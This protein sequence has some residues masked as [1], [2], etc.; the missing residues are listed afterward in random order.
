M[1]GIAGVF[2]WQNKTFPRDQFE[3]ALTSLKK[4]GPDAS[5]IFEFE[6]GFLGHRRLSIIDTS[7][8]ANQPMFDESGRYCIVFNGEI[9]NFNILKETYFKNKIFKTQSDTELLLALYTLLKEKCLDLLDGFFSFVIYD[10]ETQSLFMARD[11]FGKKPFIYFSD[12]NGFYFASEMK[13][14]IDMG[15]NR[16]INYDALYLYFQLNYV[17]Q[18]YSIF[19][20]AYKLAPGHY[21]TLTRE[22][23]FT[24]I[25][26]YTT[27]VNVNKSLT[28]E[29]ACQHLDQL[30]DEA[31]QKRLISDVPLGA[32]L[33]GGIDSS[34]I[35]ALST[36]HVNELNTFSIGYKNNPVFDET[37]FANLVAK[38]FKTNHTVFSLGEEDFLEHVVDVLDSLDE[39]FADSSAIPTYILSKLTRKHV[40]VALS[41]DGG[42]EVFSGYNKHKAEWNARQNTLTNKILQ[43]AH[44]LTK[45]LPQGRNKKITNLFRQINRYAEGVAL[46]PK[47]RYWKWASFYSVN[48]V[49]ELL[50]EKTRHQINLNTV[51]NIKSTFIDNINKTD[52]NEVLISDLKLVLPSNMLVKVD[53]MSM[54]NSLEIRSP[55]LDHH[56]VDYAF[57]LPTEFKINKQL[58]KR[59]VQD[60]FRNILP[61]EL[62]NRPKQGFEIPLRN[63]L[64][65]ELWPLIDKDLLDKKFIE[66]QGI[67]NSTHTEYL[68]KQLFSQLGE[69]VTWRIW[70]L[71]V[72]QYWW[73]R[74]V[75]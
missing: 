44:P 33:S 48:E 31:V 14:L 36:R 25:C 43:L 50:A 70:S 45:L 51:E 10:K 46:D 60:T 1:C 49:N 22:N 11:R 12:E 59:I 23:N 38:K 41:G 34:V 73:K 74:Y 52:F 56:V 68:K 26:Y 3:L 58:K 61:E 64:Q 39:P 32:F 54:A 40:T 42:D 69:D 53:L 2:T 71:I 5:G 30:L 21:A 6:H 17:P 67:F 35:V 57:T 24:S 65:R 75:K 47:S 19:K 55:F 63:W 7:E 15:L 18:P 4:R 27:K 13:S 37:Y 29:N 62:Y 72:F 28:Y 66:D 16:T 8:S 9:F 20:N